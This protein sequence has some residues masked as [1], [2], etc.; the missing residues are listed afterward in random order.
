MKLIPV[1]ES[2]IAFGP[3]MPCSWFYSRNTLTGDFVWWVVFCTGI[4]TEQIYFTSLPNWRKYFKRTRVAAEF[5][6]MCLLLVYSIILYVLYLVNQEWFLSFVC[7]NDTS[8]QE[9]DAYDI[10]NMLVYMR[11]VSSVS[12]KM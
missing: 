3:F 10:G 9:K 7:Q 4:W 6:M 12:A 11:V 1:T 8:F 2:N 5:L